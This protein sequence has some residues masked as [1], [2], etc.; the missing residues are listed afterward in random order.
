MN[1]KC[2][3]GVTYGLSVI[4][5]RNDIAQIAVILRIDAS[6]VSGPHLNGST[7]RFR[8]KKSARP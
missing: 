6:A 4:T 1:N 5:A 2:E 3:R 8:T 7:A